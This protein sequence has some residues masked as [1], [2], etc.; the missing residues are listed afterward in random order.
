M[1]NFFN[2]RSQ[3]RYPTIRQ[4]LVQ[5]GLSAAGDPAQ[6][7]VLERHGHYSGRPVNFFNAFAPGHQDLSLASGHVERE[8]AVVFDTRPEAEG[9]TPMRQPAN[10]ATHTDDERFVFGDAASARSS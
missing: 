6:V 4:A 9:G 3:P 10:R 5:A 8:G 1:F 7:A 2:H